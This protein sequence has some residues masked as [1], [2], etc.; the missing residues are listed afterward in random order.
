MHGNISLYSCLF[1][2]GFSRAQSSREEGQGNAALNRL[3]IA[4]RG[5]FFEILG[6]GLCFTNYLF[7]DLAPRPGQS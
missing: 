3:E 5:I 4:H 7:T 2:P 6:E 1:T